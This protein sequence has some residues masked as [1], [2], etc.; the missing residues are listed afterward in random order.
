M[1]N[2]MSLPTHDPTKFKLPNTIPVA[3][4]LNDSPTLRNSSHAPLP[5]PI[6]RP[7][8]K[9]LTQRCYAP[10]PNP[11]KILAFN[12]VPS[13]YEYTPLHPPTP[14]RAPCSKS[15]RLSKHHDFK[16]SCT[17]RKSHVAPANLGVYKP[18]A[19]ATD[20][21]SFPYSHSATILLFS[22]FFSSRFMIWKCHGCSD[23]FSSSR[24]RFSKRHE[25]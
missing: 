24:A 14:P 6:P 1:Y 16:Q 13:V 8:R 12:P 17:V 19:P 18:P 10:R 4:K 9:A 5:H 15:P 25:C 2:D 20:Y 11:P 3:Q 22:K 7:A 23:M 21:S